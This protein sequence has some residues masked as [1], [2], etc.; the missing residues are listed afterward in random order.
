MTINRVDLDT[1]LGLELAEV[2]DRHCAPWQVVLYVAGD[3]FFSGGADTESI[4]DSNGLPIMGPT[5]LDARR[6]ALELLPGIAR[7]V[8]QA[9]AAERARGNGGKWMFWLAALSDSKDQL[10][11]LDNDESGGTARPAD[12]EKTDS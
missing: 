3:P 2:L 9:V 6:M 11:L 1:K 4:L 5:L 8:D 12:G 7:L 10:V